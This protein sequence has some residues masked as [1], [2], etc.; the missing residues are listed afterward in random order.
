VKLDADSIDLEEH[1]ANWESVRQRLRKLEDLLTRINELSGQ[2][3][4]GGDEAEFDPSEEMPA[5]YFVMREAHHGFGRVTP[6]Y[7]IEVAALKGLDASFGLGSQGSIELANLSSQPPLTGQPTVVAIKAPQHKAEIVATLNL[8]QPEAA[9]ELKFHANQIDLAGLVQPYSPR[10]PLTL[11]GGSISLVGRGWVTPHEF[12]LA[13][14]AQLADLHVQVSA[15]RNVA[16]LPPQLWNDGLARLQGLETEATLAGRWSKPQLRIDSQ[17]LVDQFRKQLLAAGETLLAKAIDEQVNRAE[18]KV[19]QAIDQS[20]A[21]AEAAVDRQAQK[22]EAA[23][24]RTTDRAEQAVDRAAAKVDGVVS[25]GEAQV[26][27]VQQR[28]EQ[29][30]AGVQSTLDRVQG[31][32]SRTQDRYA[33]RAAQVQQWQNQ[34]GAVGRMLQEN[35]A[36]SALTAPPANP[37]SSP[38]PS[39]LPPVE[40]E[41]SGEIR[42]R[43]PPPLQYGDIVGAAG[44]ELPATTAPAVSNAPA[45]SAQPLPPAT[46]LSDGMRYPESVRNFAV[47]AAPAI[48]PHSEAA[49]IATPETR[50]AVEAGSANR[51][52]SFN[53]PPASMELGYEARRP[54]AQP[55]V[56]T[57]PADRYAD[58]RIAAGGS[59]SAPYTAGGSGKDPAVGSRAA[60]AA[61]KTQTQ[62]A[63]PVETLQQPEGVKARLGNWSRNVSGKVKGMVP[64]PRSGAEATVS[65]QPI[66]PEG[67]SGPADS[68][69]SASGPQLQSA[70]ADTPWYRR[71]WR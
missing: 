19:G 43:G 14:N 4:A 21:R 66:T 59:P 62:A 28:V 54:T 53:G 16:G 12:E 68:T 22:V 11:R 3:S 17:Q 70:P 23:V 29:S 25:K 41:T 42:R 6:K 57:A 65:D 63:A 49:P 39:P 24:D 50:P 45:A 35:V 67:Q 60:A 31:Q 37:P 36:A 1:L 38:M 51:P 33:D 55:T 64:W 61:P 32:V 56:T 52:A 26:A 44:V 13:V 47:Q 7:W 69:A 2:T 9:H 58:R 46:P 30:A 15:Q 5:S 8:H 10:A 40:Q 20:L 71:F 27:G 18:A 48:T 34:F